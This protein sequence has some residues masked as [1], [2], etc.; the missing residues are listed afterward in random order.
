MTTFSLRQSLEP[1]R[2]WLAYTHT[3]THTPAGSMSIYTGGHPTQEKKGTV[4]V[5]LKPL[6]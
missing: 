4:L 3:H 1:F 5:N 6:S 2:A